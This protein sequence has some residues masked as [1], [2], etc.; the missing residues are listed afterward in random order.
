MFQ[1][2]LENNGFDFQTKGTILDRDSKWII[3]ESYSHLIVDM[4]TIEVS[5]RIQG[6]LY[7]MYF[8]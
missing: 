6:D 1:V 8:H 2:S 3:S 7:K 4:S 5:V